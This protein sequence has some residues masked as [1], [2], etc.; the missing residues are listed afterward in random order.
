MT[1]VRYDGRVAIITGAGGN[2]GLGRAHAHLLA[3]RGAKVVVNDLGVGPDGRGT[4]QS[5]ASRVADEI[6][7]AGG[8]AIA[9]THDIS[10]PDTAR[11]VVDAALEHWGRV[12]VLIN[13]AGVVL[14]ADF[15]EVTDSDI[16]KMVDVHL[17][18]TIW[19]CRAVW[20]HMKAEG[21]GR[22]VNTSSGA[23]FG[24]RHLSIYGAAKGGI[25]G[26][27]RTLAIEGMSH[28][29]NVNALGPA[30][31]SAAVELLQDESPLKDLF[32]NKLH[33]EQVAAVV[34][35]LASEES[36]VTGMFIDA[37]GGAVSARVFAKTVGYANPDLT[38]EDL[39]ARIELVLATD[40]HTLVPP[41]TPETGAEVV[42]RPYRPG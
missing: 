2:P 35:Y 38:P 37:G 1:E 25:F 33:P 36:S 8:E 11:A 22:I 39:A 9:D 23:M 40:G 5:S 30:A 3:A 27:T 31:H 21:Y 10:R 6:V 18:G 7:A 32:V 34:A 29:I 19:M 26:L 24:L 14:F 28:G 16:E 4:R 41:L 12:D 15:D 13:N 20:S 42:V 17:M